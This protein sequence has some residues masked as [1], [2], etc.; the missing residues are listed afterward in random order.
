MHLPL[1]III[2]CVSTP[3]IIWN[4]YGGSVSIYARAGCLFNHLLI[5]D[6]PS[7]F[8]NSLYIALAPSLSFDFC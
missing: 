5:I 1:G 8:I 2:I 7:W 4:E 3:V 6:D